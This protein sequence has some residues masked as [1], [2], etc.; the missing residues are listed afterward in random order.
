VIQDNE[1]PDKNQSQR[2]RKSLW[3]MK[4]PVAGS[5]T[6]SGMPVEIAPYN[7]RFDVARQLLRM[8]G[9]KSNRLKKGERS[10]CGTNP[11]GGTYAEVQI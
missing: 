3:I 10:I 5:V 4:N 2:N 1:G 7:S 11:F 9:S 6:K 8:V